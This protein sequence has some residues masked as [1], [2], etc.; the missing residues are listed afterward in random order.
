MPSGDSPEHIFRVEQSQKI[1]AITHGAEPKSKTE[2]C[3]MGRRKRKNVLEPA[4]L[5]G[6][7]GVVFVLWLLFRNPSVFIVLGL[8][9]AAVL[10]FL[11]VI[12]AR[13]RR[14]LIYKANALADQNAERLARR[15]AQLVRQDAY[16]RLVLDKW[17]EEVNYFIDEHVRPSLTSGEQWLL[18]RQRSAITHA[19]AQ[20][21]ESVICG[22]PVFEMFSDNMTPTE[23]EAFCAEELRQAGWNA[24]VTRQSRDQGVDV[25]AEKD[26]V[27]LVL[28]CKLY[29]KPVGNKAVQEAAAARAF[30][31]AQ[32][33]AVVSN[34]SYTSATE[35]LA[36]TNKV[37]L[38]HYGDLKRMDTILREWGLHPL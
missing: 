16:G 2:R 7:A 14:R 11:I 19:I 15:R 32:Y 20:H 17:F 22:K 28:Q 38:L 27:R 31:Q 25:V 5:L 21:V 1:G 8:A 9:I 3:G 30:E 26:G 33:C 12:P 35:Q 36:S 37:L 4:T 24:S 6:L 29:S 10:A 18:R 23:F 13:T 34:I